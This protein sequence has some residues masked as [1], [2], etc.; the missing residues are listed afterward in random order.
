MSAWNEQIAS[1]TGG[2]SAVV[3]FNN[4]WTQQAW[5]TSDQDVQDRARANSRTESGSFGQRVTVTQ[6]A[7][8]PIDEFSDEVTLADLTPSGPDW[9]E[10]VDE[11]A[12]QEAYLAELEKAEKAEQKARP[13]PRNKGAS[14][15]RNRKAIGKCGWT[16][17]RGYNRAW[18]DEVVVRVV[19]V[20]VE[21]HG[22]PEGVER[23]GAERAKETTERQRAWWVERAR[24][25]SVAKQKQEKRVRVQGPHQQKT[26]LSRKEQLLA[27]FEKQG[28]NVAPGLPVHILE[29]VLKAR[30]KERRRK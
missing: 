8:T 7:Y 29:N 30:R 13:K 3:S 1:I 15:P 11:D 21:H 27:E 20:E 23:V 19:T 28:I 14:K 22:N 2:S 25:A 16:A 10:V 6:G 5:D 4:E 9:N 24:K 26:Q 18:A 12:Q 17:E